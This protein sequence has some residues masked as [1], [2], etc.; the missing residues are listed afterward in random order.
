MLANIALEEDSA[1]KIV[2]MGGIAALT[3]CLSSTSAITVE[4]AT[5]ALRRLA[6]VP[7][8]ADSLVR[9]FVFNV[10]RVCVHL[11]LCMHV[12]VCVHVC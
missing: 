12:H 7:S 6:S 11:C 10:F 4:N 8:N 1:C 2:D 9:C 5:K 3:A